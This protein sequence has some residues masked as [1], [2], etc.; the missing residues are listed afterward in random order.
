MQ[1]PTK[2]CPV[3]FRYSSEVEVLA[4]EHPLAGRQ[5]VKG[6]IEAG[7]TPAQAAVRELYEEAGVRSRV[8]GDLGF[9]N[10]GGEHVWSFQLCA[11]VGDLEESWVHHALDDGGHNFR[12]FWQPLSRE[13]EA[14]W[15]AVFL[16][17][18]AYIRSTSSNKLFDTDAQVRPLP[19]VAPSS[20]AGQL[21]R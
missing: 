9:F 14:G 16:S 6:T 7:E 2:V 20:C 11:P 19:S 5:L 3:V 1:H 12:F 4:F 17:A 13:P 15:H 10:P 21:R 18:L 8:T